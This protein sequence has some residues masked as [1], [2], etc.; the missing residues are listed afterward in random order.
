MDT[1]NKG[2]H[3]NT[4]FVNHSTLAKRRVSHDL[5]EIK[6]KKMRKEFFMVITE[7]H[8]YIL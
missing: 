2:K 1:E 6:V 5:Y 8:D 7:T 4:G 3:E